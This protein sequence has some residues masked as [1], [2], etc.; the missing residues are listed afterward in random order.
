MFYISG[1]ISAFTVPGLCCSPKEYTTKDGQCC[2][3]CHEGEAKREVWHES[4]NQW[5]ITFNLH[6]VCTGTAWL[7]SVF[8]KPQSGGL[9]RSP[10]VPHSG[11]S[12]KGWV[13]PSTGNC[14]Y[15]LYFILCFV[16]RLM[17]DGGC[18]SLQHP[19]EALTAR[20]V[21]PRSPMTSWQ[22]QRFPN[23]PNGL[24]IRHGGLNC[25]SVWVRWSSDKTTLYT[26]GFSYEHRHCVLQFS[27]VSETS[28]TDTVQKGG[29]NQLWFML[30]NEKLSFLLKIRANTNRGWH[31]AVWT[32]QA[33]DDFIILNSTLLSPPACV[34][35]HSWCSAGEFSVSSATWGWPLPTLTTCWLGLVSAVRPATPD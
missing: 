6:F 34:G 30:E 12:L 21:S 17:F 31:G 22:H 14:F 19:A 23:V 5:L 2:A 32:E 3:L 25:C 4:C 26:T 27:K 15:F 1:W 16:F 28:A 24:W 9:W 7:I 35:P 20:T 11:G 33:P 8:R 29:L 10:S 13:Y 18:C